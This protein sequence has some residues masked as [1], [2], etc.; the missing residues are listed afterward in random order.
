M[1]DLRRNAWLSGI[2][3]YVHTCDF[4]MFCSIVF[5]AFHAYC[6][7]VW[8]WMYLENSINGYSLKSLHIEH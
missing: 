7:K 1:N 4:V 2:N 5:R 3:Y 8:L 6:A